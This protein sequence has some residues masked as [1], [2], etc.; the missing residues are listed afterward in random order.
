MT[1]SR[2]NIREIPPLIWQVHQG[3]QNL[4]LKAYKSSFL[5]SAQLKLEI[6]VDFKDLNSCRLKW[7]VVNTRDSNQSALIFKIIKAHVYLAISEEELQENKIAYKREHSIPRSGRVFLC[8]LKI[9]TDWPLNLFSL[10]RVK[11]AKQ[12]NN[13]TSALSWDITSVS[14]FLFCNWYL[15]MTCLT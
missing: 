10:E 8:T 3:K 15:E 6:I 7:K 4:L 13:Q 9:R 12:K 5:Y 14:Y 2:I 1:K 11:E